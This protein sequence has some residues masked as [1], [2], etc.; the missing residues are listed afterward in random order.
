[1]TL[2]GIAAAAGIAAPSIYGHFTDRAAIWD[3]VSQQSWEQ[4]VEEILECATQGG[5]PRERLFHGCR[6]YVAYAQRYPGRYSLMTQLSATTPAA[7]RA[8]EVITGALAKC[9]ADFSEPSPAD[10]RRIVSTLAT[11][12]HG[13]AMLSNTDAPSLWLSGVST[14]EVIQTLVRNAVDDLSHLADEPGVPGSR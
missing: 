4:V 12:L 10:S 3:A 14:D 2:R 7:T 11:A 13:V 9:R 8:L 6:A 5:T 1:M